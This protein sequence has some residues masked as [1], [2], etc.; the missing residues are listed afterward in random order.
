MTKQEIFEKTAQ[1]HTVETILET[2]STQTFVDWYATKFADYIGA[3]N[4]EEEEKIKKDI[5]RLFGV[6]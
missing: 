6:E 5:K 4:E 1:A 2:L 3:Y